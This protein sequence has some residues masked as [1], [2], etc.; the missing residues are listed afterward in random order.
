VQEG[1]RAGES[2]NEGDEDDG[3]DEAVMF[4]EVFAV[5]GDG[6]ELAG[7]EGDGSG[8]VGLDREQAS[9]Q[10]RGEDEESAATGDGVDEAAETS[11]EGQ[12]NVLEERGC[13]WNR[14]QG[15]GYRLRARPPGSGHGSPCEPD[16]A[17][18]DNSGVAATS[19]RV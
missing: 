15:A 16:F 10:E 11:R 5:A 14:V 9:L 2:T 1:E 17:Q 18:D 4:A 6:G 8:S 19:W 12:K 3:D 13:T 7:P